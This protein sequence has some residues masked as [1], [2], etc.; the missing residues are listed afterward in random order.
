LLL[1][2]QRQRQRERRERVGMRDDVP[3]RAQGKEVYSLDQIE[4]IS[5]FV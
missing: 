3:H 5:V 4:Y 2:E 1:L